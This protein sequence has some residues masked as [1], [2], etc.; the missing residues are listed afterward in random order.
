MKLINAVIER[1]KYYLDKSRNNI[2]SDTV[3]LGSTGKYD[4]IAENEG[5]TY[6]KMSDDAWALLEKEAGGNYDEIWKVYDICAGLEIELDEFFNCD[7]LKL[8]N[9]E[10]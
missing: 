4:V 6:F 3:I 9:I 5:Y 7:S 2:E 8:I 10:D 1:I